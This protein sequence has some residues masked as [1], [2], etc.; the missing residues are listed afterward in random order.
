[1]FRQNTKDDR[2]I[3]F[4]KIRNIKMIIHFVKFIVLTDFK[5]LK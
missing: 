2:K 4:I 3:F 5:D 1:M